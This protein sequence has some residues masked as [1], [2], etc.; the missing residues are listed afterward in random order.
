MAEAASA[1]AQTTTAVSPCGS[2]G[3]GAAFGMES[4]VRLSFCGDYALLERAVPA[5]KLLAADCGLK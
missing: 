2:F 5:L 3:G 1:P 4:Y